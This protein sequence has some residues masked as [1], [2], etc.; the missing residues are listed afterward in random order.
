MLIHGSIFS[1]LHL[2]VIIILINDNNGKY[3]KYC[4]GNFRL[5][6]NFAKFAHFVNSRKLSARESKKVYVYKYVPWKTANIKCQR[7][8]PNGKRR[9][10]GAA[11]ISCY[12]ALCFS[13]VA[14]DP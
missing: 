12:T 2:L 5:H 8:V 6:F 13:P 4:T 14:V 11:N 9:T 7:N 10:F 1:D 3:C